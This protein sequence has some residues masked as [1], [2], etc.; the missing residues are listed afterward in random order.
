MKKMGPDAIPEPRRT[1]LREMYGDELLA[2]WNGV[3]DE[4]IK[5][6]GSP[7]Y[8]KGDNGTFREL[9][10]NVQ[11]PALIIHGLKDSLIDVSDAEYL[12]ST[13]RNSRLHL[14]ENG[15]HNLHL[16]ETKEFV[17]CIQNFIDN[18]VRNQS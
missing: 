6:T 16:R 8:Q 7:I 14:M 9:V 1:Q 5:M 15:T 13:L 10:K 3:T 11:C 4:M 18:V 17:S 2:M 12:N